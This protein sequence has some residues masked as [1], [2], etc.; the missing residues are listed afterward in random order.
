MRAGGVAGLD[1]TSLANAGVRLAALDTISGLV[2]AVGAVVTVVASGCICG[3]CDGGCGDRLCSAV[4]AVETTLCKVADIIAC[5]I[6]KPGKRGATGI[7]AAVTT[8]V[9]TRCS[10][11]ERVALLIVSP[12]LTPAAQPIVIVKLW[13]CQL[14]L[15]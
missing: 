5:S 3:C 10:V 14:V 8:I 9:T 6:A 15:V 4:A 11:A 1:I 13:N 7:D 2:A 12:G